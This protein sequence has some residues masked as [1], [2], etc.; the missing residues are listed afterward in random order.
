[1]SSKRKKQPNAHRHAGSHAIATLVTTVAAGLLVA[2]YKERLYMLVKG[3]REVS[4]WLLAIY[5]L[6]FTVDTMTSV[7]VATTLS[8]CWG[9]AFH[10]A[11]R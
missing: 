6:P 3:F 5:D 8:A 11:H 7:L 9:I 10:Y 4:L 2:Y 1:M